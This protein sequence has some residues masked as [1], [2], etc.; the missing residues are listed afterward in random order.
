MILC[1]VMWIW[2]LP[3]FTGTW[4]ETRWC[5]G[6]AL[7]SWSSAA[8]SPW[9]KTKEREPFFLLFLFVDVQDIHFWSKYL[10]NLVGSSGKPRN[11]ISTLLNIFILQQFLLSFT[12][13]KNPVA[14]GNLQCQFYI[15]KFCAFSPENCLTVS[16]GGCHDDHCSGLGEFS[17]EFFFSLFFFP[18]DSYA[19]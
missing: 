1:V 15:Q 8:C 3:H 5:C 17:A 6:L 2:Q 19:G 12:T 14:A 18:L 13:F 7:L 9:G 16:W 4:T 11:L 10:V